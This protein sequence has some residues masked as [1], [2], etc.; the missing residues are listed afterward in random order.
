MTPW[1]RPA[2]H[3][4]VGALLQLLPRHDSSLLD[5]G[6]GVG[7]GE[8]GGVLRGPGE[9]W[10]RSYTTLLTGGYVASL[11]AHTHMHTSTHGCCSAQHIAVLKSIRPEEG[12]R[13]KG[14]PLEEKRARQEAVSFII[15][16]RAVLLSLCHGPERKVAFET[17]V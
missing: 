5:Q 16:E 6:R 11:S 17:F 8:G 2:H 1:P 4:S 13:K 9:A 14:S 15:L 10:E 7:R 12:K 3:R